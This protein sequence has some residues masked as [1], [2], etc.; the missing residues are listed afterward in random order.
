M[1]TTEAPP[2]TTESWTERAVDLAQLIAPYAAIHDREGSFVNEAFDLIRLYGFAGAMVPTDLGGGGA[3]HEEGAAIL[4]ELAKGCPATAVT[5][6]MHY[7]L[8]ATQVWR[9][10]HGQPAETILRR[11]ADENLILIS[12][13]ATDWVDSYG[14]ATKVDGGFRVS[15]RKQPSSG[16]PAGDL[17]VASVPWADSPNGA[18]VIHCAI[19]FTSEGV[20]IEETWNAMGLRGTGSHTVVRDD[21]FVPDSAVT[22]IRPT[23]QWHPLWNVV[24]GAALP[25]IMSAYVGIGEAAVD[26]ALSHAGRKAETPHVAP[27][28]GEML[29]HLTTARDSVDAML[30]SSCNLE[31]DATIEHAGVTLARKTVATEA[32]IATVRSALDVCGGA[33]YGVNSGLERLFRDIHGSLFHPLPVAK[34]TRFSGRV[35]LGLDPVQV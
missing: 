11:V 6:S 12:T 19:P 2:T 3:S 23:S 16:A 26:I 4:R 5:L 21:V 10:N 22:L 25:L 24:L 29:N 18:Q 32:L 7:H 15:A 34:Q 14:D 30:H 9:H 8:V 1:T 33:G 28:V 35:A 31:F 17:L 27:L 13:G 20:R